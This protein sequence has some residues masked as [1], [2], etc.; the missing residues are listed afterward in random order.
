MDTKGFRRNTF[1]LLSNEKEYKILIIPNLVPDD[2][3][4]IFSSNPDNPTIQLRE[5]GGFEQKGMLISTLSP[6]L[7]ITS[8]A[9][10]NS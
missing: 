5:G 1:F 3:L 10:L 8:S 2:R 7:T 9:T 4:I 6:A